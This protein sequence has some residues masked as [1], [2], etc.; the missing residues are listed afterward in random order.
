MPWISAG[1]GVHDEIASVMLKR[2]T[3]RKQK[4]LVVSKGRFSIPY[5]VQAGDV[6]PISL[7]QIEGSIDVGGKATLRI[8]FSGDSLPGDL[9]STLPARE[10]T[11]D[12]VRAFALTMTFSANGRDYDARLS[13]GT[14]CEHIYSDAG[15]F[16]QGHS[17]SKDRGAKCTSDVECESGACSKGFCR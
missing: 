10:A 4:T 17:G 14:S 15:T 9:V 13:S 3:D 11:L 6:G 8:R 16:K 1:L 2:L 5:R 7:G 12:Y